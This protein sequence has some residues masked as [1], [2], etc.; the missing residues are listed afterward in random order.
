MAKTI[1]T[2]I[3]HTKNISTITDTNEIMIFAVSEI[4]AFLTQ[5]QTMIINEVVLNFESKKNIF[6]R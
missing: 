3:Q 5:V 4:S 1:T 6:E 2:P